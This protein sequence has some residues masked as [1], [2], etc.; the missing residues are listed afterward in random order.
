MPRPPFDPEAF[1]DLKGLRDKYEEQKRKQCE[2]AARSHPD[3]PRLTRG[4]RVICMCTSP[5]STL[6]PD[7]D[8]DERG[9]S[10][11]VSPPRAERVSDHGDRPSLP[12]SSDTLGEVM[13]VRQGAVSAAGSGNLRADSPLCPDEEAFFE[14]GVRKEGTRKR[15]LSPQSDLAPLDADIWNATDSEV[16]SAMCA[17]MCACRP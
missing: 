5:S 17:E 2:M 7:G 9:V 12:L 6:H 14:S 13:H 15:P 11:S 1:A 16:F 3:S 10:P 4:G 8:A